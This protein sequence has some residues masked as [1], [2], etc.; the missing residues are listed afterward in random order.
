MITYTWS[1]LEVFGDQTIA[2]VRYLLKA[3]DEQNIVET[4]GYHEY[5]ES[6]VC[7]P[8]SEIKESD[9]IGWLESDTIKDGVNAIKL[10]LENQLKTLKT[11]NKIGFPWEAETF[12]IG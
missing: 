7:K 12:T 5:S 9:L 4:E 10:N 3:Q 8:L 1:I 2:K 6:L 11:S